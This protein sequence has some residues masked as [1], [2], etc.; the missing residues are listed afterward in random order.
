MQSISP[1][2]L[3]NCNDNDLRD[4]FVAV[5]RDLART[6]PNSAER[7]EALWSLETVAAAMYSRS[8]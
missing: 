4:I 1:F 2:T 6:K 7:T 8:R 3:T 5:S